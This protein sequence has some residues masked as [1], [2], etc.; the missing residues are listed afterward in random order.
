MFKETELEKFLSFLQDFEFE[1]SQLQ[2]GQ[3]LD[4][5][6]FMETSVNFELENKEMMNK[7]E[8][9]SKDEEMNKNKKR[10]ENLNS[11]QIDLVDEF[12]QYFD[13]LTL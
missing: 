8:Q 11:H 12:A 3:K 10:L 13:E 6:S 4:F 9:A 1:K 7:N 5:N 2:N